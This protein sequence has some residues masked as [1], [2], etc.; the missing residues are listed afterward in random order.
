MPCTV[1]HVLASTRADHGGTSR[2]VP[3][4]CEALDAEGVE[5]HLVTA[6]PADPAP[7]EEPVLPDGGVQVH[8]IEERTRLQRTLRSPMGFY[9]GLWSVVEAVQPDVIHD[10]GAWLPSNVVSAW[11]ARQ[12]SVPLVVASHGMVTEWALSHQAWK[13]RIAWHLYQRQVFKAVNLFQATAPAEVDDLRALG[14]TQPIAV[15]PNGVELPDA[16]PERPETNGKRALFLSRLHPKKGLPMLLDAWADLRPEGWTLELVGPSENGHREELEAQASELDLDGNVVFSGPVD[17]ADKWHKYAAA[18][19]F[20]LPTH[21]ENFGIVVA[22]ALAAEVPVLTTTGTPW[23]ELEAHECG[24]WVEPAPEAIRDA[25]ATALRQ[26]D[27]TRSAMGRRG[28][29]L[30]T[31]TYT[32][33]AVGQRMRRAYEW[34]LGAGASRP[35]FIRESGSLH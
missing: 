32:W 6:V 14:M 19:L 7:D 5:V 4:L 25:L 16:L 13:K 21:S 26:S 10:N 29:E 9:R 2:S 28:R 27:A 17:D 20:V 1:V 23:Q 11:V 15:V 8:R 33:R 34:L 30:V 12:A 35:S 31:S 22:E 18:D 3:A 24:W